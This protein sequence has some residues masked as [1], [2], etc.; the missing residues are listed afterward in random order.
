MD[1]R[2]E[3]RSVPAPLFD[4]FIAVNTALKPLMRDLYDHDFEVRPLYLK[5][6]M[7]VYAWAG[8]MPWEDVVEIS[9]T[10]EGD[11]VMLMLRTADHL[12]HVISLAK[13]FPEAA[14]TAWKAVELILKAPVWMDI[15]Q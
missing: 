11:M 2:V 8:G 15:D 10:A 13:T 7:A 9:D 4:A 14:E 3:R 5:P 1:D 12:R 6:A